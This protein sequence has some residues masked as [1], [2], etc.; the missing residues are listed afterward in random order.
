LAVFLIATVWLPAVIISLSLLAKMQG[1][2]V[3]A[4]TLVIGSLILLWRWLFHTITYREKWAIFCLLFSTIVIGS[5]FSLFF[6][7]A[8]TDG[9]WYHADAILGLLHDI[10]PI[11]AQFPADQPVW[12]NHYPKAT[13]YFAALLIHASGCYQIGKVYNFLLM[14]A[15]AFYGADFFRRLGVSRWHSGFLTFALAANPVAVAQMATYY[16]DGALG[17]LLALL[18][19]A[20]VNIVFKPGALDWIVFILSASL[21]IGIKFT[22]IPYLGTIICVLV[23]I[24]ML[25]QKVVTCAISRTPVRIAMYALIASCLGIL[26]LG[27]NPYITNIEQGLNPLY[28]VLGLNRIDIITPNSPE[29][30]LNPSYS[31]GQK[32]LIS[33][34]G[35]T[36]AHSPCD[37]ILVNGHRAANLGCH[38]QLKIP[39]TVSKEELISLGTPEIHIGAWGVFFSGVTLGTLALFLFSRGWRRN[40]PIMLAVSLVAISG[41]INPECWW[42]RYVPQISLI[43]VFLLIPVLQNRKVLVRGGAHIL[44]GFLVVNSFLSAAAAAGASFIKSQKLE[45]SFAMIARNGGAGEYWAYRNPDKPEE[46]WAYRNPDSKVHFEQ[47][48]GHQGIRICGEIDAPGPTLPAGGFPVGL[49]MRGATEVTLY[50]GNCSAGPPFEPSSRVSADN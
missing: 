20:S 19:L 31:R 18:I 4:E 26:V 46:S 39:F 8:S 42:A 37:T 5:C 35:K 10:N 38:E 11:Y 48:S 16:V 28:P 34:L 27:F 47:F 21:A 15:C 32:F 44:C 50:R 7:D 12:S 36:L 29:S 40:A 24:Q 23:A 25:P 17:S 22:A 2:W 49:N 41:F 9:R 45:K 1:D 6:Y 13:W 33:F 30:F 43:P 3:L 14:F